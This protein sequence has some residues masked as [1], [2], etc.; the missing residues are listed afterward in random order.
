MWEEYVFDFVATV[1]REHR[2][3]TAAQ[4]P[5]ADP[6]PASEIPADPQADVPTVHDLERLVA[7]QAEVL[8]LLLLTPPSQGSPPH[9][10]PQLMPPRSPRRLSPAFRTRHR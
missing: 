10:R 3:R 6:A 1:H 5:R 7:P 8:F 2:L 9:S 4:P